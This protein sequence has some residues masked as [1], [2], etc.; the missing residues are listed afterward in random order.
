MVLVSAAI[1]PHGTMLLDPC[2]AGLPAGVAPLRAACELTA[3]AVAAS[4]P[5]TLVLVT[6]HGAALSSQLGVYLNHTAAGSA[7]WNGAWVDYTV[8]C[9]TDVAM[10]EELL[11]HFSTHGIA[12]DGIVSFSQGCAAPLMW[13]EVVPLHFIYA[14][15]DFLFQIIVISI[16][17][18]RFFPQSYAACAA[19]WGRELDAFLS[20]QSKR[21]AIVFSCD[22]SHVHETPAGTMSAFCGDASLGCNA[23]LARDFD[24]HIRDWAA[25]L[26]LGSCAEANAILYN[27]AL[28]L[29]E[30][31]KAC[32]W[33][34]CCALQG[35][36]ERRDERTST[37]L[38]VSKRL[39]EKKRQLDH[40][41]DVHVDSSG[42]GVGGVAEGV[43]NSSSSGSSSGST[44]GAGREGGAGG[45]VHGYTAPTYFGMMAT[46]MFSCPP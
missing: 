9:E 41:K 35:L 20:A 12:A 39:I 4:R 2:M 31:A 43:P 8:A 10:S 3:A 6:P 30:Q 14:N 36:M 15:C 34:G 33:A 46:S 29:V 18:E 38:Q 17:R 25:K 32:G 11:A 19:A 27:D 44:G 45:V 24:F 1:L 42:V 23:A 13:G 40:L 21:V 28:P 7:A 22:L 37:T 26:A 16:P 5:D